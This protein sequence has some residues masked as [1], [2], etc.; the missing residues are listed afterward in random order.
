ML[1][2]TMPG[3]TAPERREALRC[4]SQRSINNKIAVT[5]AY[6]HHWAVSIPPS[7]L[8]SRSSFEEEAYRET[9][10]ASSNHSVQ[11]HRWVI[12]QHYDP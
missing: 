1:L 6:K 3:T 2:G 4:S 5:G 7:L 9:S 10:E 12:H 8:N 11:K